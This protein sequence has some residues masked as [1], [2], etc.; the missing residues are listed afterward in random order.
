MTLFFV[1]AIEMIVMTIWTK[2]VTKN[3][4]ILTGIITTFNILI[5]Y[6]V[7]GEVVNNLGN[8]TTIVSYTLGSSVGAMAS[9]IDH[10]KIVEWKRMYKKVLQPKRALKTVAKPAATTIV[11]QSSMQI[12]NQ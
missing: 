4:T 8:W 5:W 2:V 12:V 7:V 3:S 9:T 1:G 6:Y 11:T 10:A